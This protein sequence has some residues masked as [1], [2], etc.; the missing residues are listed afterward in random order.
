VQKSRS[1]MGEDLLKQT[2][3]CQNFIKALEG[4]H[5]SRV[6]VVQTDFDRVQCRGEAVE[7]G[8]P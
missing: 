5:A 4:I 1:L 6:R 2:F 3:S 7:S 8:A